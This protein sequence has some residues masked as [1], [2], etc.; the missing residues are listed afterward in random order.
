M[1]AHRV[2]DNTMIEAAD[3]AKW[4]NAC[5]YLRAVTEHCCTVTCRRADGE[6]LMLAW[7]ALHD[8]YMAIRERDFGRTEGGFG[9]ADAPRMSAFAPISRRMMPERGERVPLPT[10][11]AEINGDMS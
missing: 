4:D 9:R 7:K 6:R 5:A 11:C 2:S 1:T 3:Q 8:E 10:V